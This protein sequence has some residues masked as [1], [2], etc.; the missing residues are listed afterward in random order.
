MN[1]NSVIKNK[2]KWLPARVR[3]PGDADIP[4]DSEIWVEEGKSLDEA[5]KQ[6]EEEGN[7]TFF[8]WL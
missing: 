6:F 5:A 7:G 1:T 2:G 4:H 3:G 8:F